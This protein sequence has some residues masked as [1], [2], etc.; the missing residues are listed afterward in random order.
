MQQDQRSE[1]RSNIWG[2]LVFFRCEAAPAEDE[3]LGIVEDIGP[4]GLFIATRHPPAVGTVLRLHLYS[5]SGPAG[6]SALDA[7]AVVRWRAAGPERKGVGVQLLDDA[8]L[9]DR[10]LEPWLDTLAPAPLQPHRP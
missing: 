9:E 4:S 5:Q 3:R 6:S 2:T 10:G 1:Y 7:Q 8:Q